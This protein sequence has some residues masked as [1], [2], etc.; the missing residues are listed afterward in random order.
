MEG[1]YSVVNNFGEYKFTV[2][3][4]EPTQVEIV[5]KSGTTYSGDMEDG[6]LTGTAQI[7]YSNGDKY[8]GRVING[9]KSG[10]GSYEWKSGASYEGDWSEDK[11]H[12]QGTYYYSDKDDGYKL[13]GNFEK[14][15]PNG[16]CQY[17]VDYYESFQTDWTNGK[18][19]KIYE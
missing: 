6:K 16:Q 2:E 12:G 3:E 4:S 8:S 13:I 17:Y 1:L 15:R 9:Y 14:G 5:L 11:M 7:T 10:Q 18:C 19:V